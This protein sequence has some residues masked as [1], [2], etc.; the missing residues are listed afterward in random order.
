MTDK[1]PLTFLI[2]GVHWSI[3]DVVKLI[4]LNT[5]LKTD[6][7]ICKESAQANYEQYKNKQEQLTSYLQNIR[8]LSGKN[9]ILTDAVAELKSILFQKELA[10]AQN[11]GYISRVRELDTPREERMITVPES[12]VVS[13][14]YTSQASPM[15]TDSYGTWGLR[16]WDL[17]TEKK[18]R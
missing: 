15:S 6:L 3:E 10:I 5:Q 4:E 11:S 12:K 16:W 2:G 14:Q 9:V 18:E 7:Q 17:G 1:V 13:T 8:E